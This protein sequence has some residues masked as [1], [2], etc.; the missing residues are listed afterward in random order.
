[1]ATVRIYYSRADQD[2]SNWNLFHF[3]GTMDQEDAVAF[4]S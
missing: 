2:Y 4:I 1:M 3:P